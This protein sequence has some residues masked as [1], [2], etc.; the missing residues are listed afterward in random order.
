MLKKYFL[1][2]S[3]V[4]VNLIIHGHSINVIT[5]AFIVVQRPIVEF[6]VENRAAVKAKLLRAQKS[7]ENFR[8]VKMDLPKKNRTVYAQNDSEVADYSGA[9]ADPKIKNLPTHSGP[10][11]RHQK[12]PQPQEET[13]SRKPKISRKMFKNPSKRK[14]MKKNSNHGVNT[15]IFIVQYI[16]IEIIFSNVLFQMRRNHRWKRKRSILRLIKRQQRGKI[17]AT[18]PSNRNGNGLIKAIWFNTINQ[19]VI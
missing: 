17:R 1:S 4:I 19:F 11:I 18:L 6:S 3:S 15:S 7:Q 9:K 16:D 12:R 13:S 8:K 14:N 5:I 10:K 2:T